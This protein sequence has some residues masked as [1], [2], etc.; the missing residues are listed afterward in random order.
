[1]SHA[2]GEDPLAPL[3][4]R[5]PVVFVP[6]REGRDCLAV[7]TFL[8]PTGGRTGV[9]FTTV[10]RLLD[11]LGPEVAWTPLSERVLR[12]MLSLVGVDVLTVDP[13]LSAPA[14]DHDPSVPERWDTRRLDATLPRTPVAVA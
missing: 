7:R 1:M 13:T 10:A 2:H 6:V 14:V 9:A 8:T 12:G 3:P 4:A 11:V 5:S